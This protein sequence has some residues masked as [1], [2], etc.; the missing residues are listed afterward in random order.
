MKHLFTFF[1][2]LL[3]A[4]LAAKF[5][6]RF[7]GMEGLGYLLGLT[8]IFMANV[9]FF[10]FL[11]YRSHLTWRRRRAPREDTPVSPSPPPSPETPPEA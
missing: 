5:L 7:F 4:F 9:Y 8:L 2:R 3:L 1:F 11:D 6:V 10:D